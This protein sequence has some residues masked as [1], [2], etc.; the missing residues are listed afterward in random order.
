MW[1]SVK[2]MGL[3]KQRGSPEEECRVL[4]GELLKYATD[5]AP[6]NL[7]CHE[8]PPKEWWTCMQ[9]QPPNNPL[10]ALAIV[11]LDACPTAAFPERVF[12]LMGF[13]KTK[14][15]NRMNVTTLAATTTIKVHQQALIT[16][17]K[18]EHQDR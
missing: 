13:T 11:L 18:G 10:A 1:F 2:A 3:M 12:S 17:A 4:G 15:R 8:L 7:P 5:R 16:R 9:T 6:Y 14:T